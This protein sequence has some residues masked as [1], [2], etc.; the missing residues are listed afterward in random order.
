MMLERGERGERHIVRAACARPMD[1]AL[2]IYCVCIA[3]LRST[4]L[5]T[6]MYIY[7]LVLASN[8]P[9]FFFQGAHVVHNNLESDGAYTVCQ[10]RISTA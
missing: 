1:G 4:T 10:N 3:L 2:L 8:L 7:V 5:Y 6:S 9:F